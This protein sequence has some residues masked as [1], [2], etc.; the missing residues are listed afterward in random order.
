MINMQ[1]LK[2]NWE[3]IKG[4]LLQRW[5][6]LTNDDLAEFQGDAD[7]L[8]GLIHRKTGEAY[9]AVEKHLQELA[10]NA[11]TTLGAASDS[12]R[13]YAGQAA[14]KVQCTAKHAAEHL[15][16]CCAETR[17]FVCDQPLKTLVVFFGVGLI[18]GLIVAVAHHCKK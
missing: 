7:Q 8:I 6:K 15:H 11:A 5:G 16:S 2:G 12:A 17:R 14:K 1:I 18:A 10:D 13:E 4:R 9:E 3:E